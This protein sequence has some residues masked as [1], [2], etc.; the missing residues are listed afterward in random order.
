[1]RNETRWDM[2]A[3]RMQSLHNIYR[4]Y[5]SISNRTRREK[6]FVLIWYSDEAKRRDLYGTVTAQRL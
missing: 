6:L 4:M 5:K 2:F 1:M 3:G